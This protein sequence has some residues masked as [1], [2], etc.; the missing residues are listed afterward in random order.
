MFEAAAA[1]VS[2]DDDEDAHVDDGHENER[3]GEHT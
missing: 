3:Q 1:L 2:A